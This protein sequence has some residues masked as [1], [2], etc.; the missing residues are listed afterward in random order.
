MENL[1]KLKDKLCELTLELLD[2]DKPNNREEY[3]RVKSLCYKI[4]QA[5]E[6]ISV[7]ESGSRFAN[8]KQK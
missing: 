2:T 6:S 3:N 4:E 7:I 8:R 1:Q 5:R